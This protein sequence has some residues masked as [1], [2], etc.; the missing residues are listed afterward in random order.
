M[1]LQIPQLPVEFMNRDHAHAAEQ[2]AAMTDALAGYTADPASLAGLCQAFLEH[3]RAHF[4]RE[5]AAMQAAGFPPYPVHK[6]EHDR[7]LA[8]LE[9]IVQAL[10]RGL[11]EAEAGRLVTQ[12]LP[13]WLL[14]HVETMDRIT[15]HWLAAHAPGSGMPV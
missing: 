2:L 6:A 14:Q 9:G 10:A 5:E 8:N 12:A 3:N 15:A 4:A 11:P 13:H 7:V 1:T